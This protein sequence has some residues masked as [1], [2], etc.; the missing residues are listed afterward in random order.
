[1]IL[2]TPRAT[3]RLFLLAAVSCLALAAPA[4]AADAP[5]KTLVIAWGGVPEGLD[6]DALRPYTQDAVVEINEPL[7]QYARVTGPDGRVTLDGSKP[8]GD[9]AE[10]W[11]VQNGGKRVVFKLHEGVK[12][13][14]GNELT[15]ADVVWS[16]Q[17]SQA[18]KR[19]GAFIGRMGSVETVEQVSKY[20]VAFNLSAPSSMLLSLL[21]LYVPGIYDTTELK[22]HV[23]ADDPWALNWLTTH[24]ASFGPYHLESIRPQEQAVFVV[25]PNYFRPKPEFT[26]VVIR[27]VPSSGERI[28]L[29]KSGQVQW[30]ERPTYQQ[31][32]SLLN[33]KQVKVEGTTG[34]YFQALWMNAKYPPFDDIRVRQALNYAVDRD[35]IRK[36][37]FFGLSEPAPGII[38]PMLAGAKAGEISYP[39]DPAKAK[40]LL[41]AA[42]HASDLKMSID[43]SNIYPWLETGAVQLAAQLKQVGIDA[44]PQRMTDSDMRVALAPTGHT[45]PLFVWEDGPIVLDP[46]YSLGL[47]AGSDGVSNRNGY[48]NKDFDSLVAQARVELDPVKRLALVEKAQTVVLADVPYVL[49]G[50][51][52]VFEAMA[53]TMSGWVPYPDDHE[54][55]ADLHSSK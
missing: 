6:G 38:P 45:M 5:G 51:A 37:V 27:A 55:W 33:D 3:A 14:Y 39:Y 25:N 41:A 32:A 48:V 12:S 31:I 13:P 17:K 1:M 50:V 43:Y 36:S 52:K 24:T 4:R 47:N 34:R 16:W 49:L 20:E 21:T 23:T 10:S 2:P 8:Q 11:D 54:R 7:M 26:R 29:L 30:I 22:Q 19:T 44:A 35:A 40:E 28:L 42:G 53:P 18:E 46:V 15:A 9:L